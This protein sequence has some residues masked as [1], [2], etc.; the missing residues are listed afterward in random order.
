MTELLKTFTAFMDDPE[1]SEM[2]I[3]GVAGTGKTTSLKELIQYCLDNNISNV[4]AAYTHKA[5]GVLRSKLP[6]E[7]K[8]VTLH[9]FLGK[10]PTVN[11]KAT[12]IHQVDGNSQVGVPEVVRVLFI[13]E[14]SMVGEKDFMSLAEIK[15]DEDGELR[16]KIVYIGDPNQLPPVKDAKAVIPSK[17]YWVKLTTVHRQANDNPLIDTLL[18]L[19]DYINGR[20]PEALKEHQS[21]IRGQDI[22]NL[23]KDCDTSKILLAY[24]NAQVELLNKQVQG[25]EVPI[26]GDEL[27]SP[28]TRHT[29]TLVESVKSTTGIVNINGKLIEM[30]SKYKTL[31]TI[32][33]IEGINFY[34][35]EDYE[36]NEI[37]LAGVFG[38]DTFLQLQKSLAHKAVSLNKLITEK[39]NTDAKEWS[40][41]N[42]SHELAKKRAKAWSQYLAFKDNVFCLDF[43]HA[44]TVH[45]SQGSTYENVFLD[46]KDMA[47]CA[48]NDYQLY[49]KLLYVAISRASNKVYT[50]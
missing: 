37:P 4:T 40:Q 36:G 3:T 21:L 31:E 34:T 5:C 7:A 18:I 19:N 32:H 38:H 26:V 42:W 28:T 35:V 44:M 1:E 29:Y 48:D 22:V 47:K 25:R 9:S 33:D 46:T 41:A 27:F 8:T 50:N 15:Y 6:K 45:K 23:Y 39:F 24:T 12:K 14:F 43:K 11:D 30:G 2:F 20:T 13:D 17:P 10:R 49:L 16:T